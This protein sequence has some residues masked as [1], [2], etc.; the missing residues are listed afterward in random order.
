MTLANFHPSATKP[1]AWCLTPWLRWFGPV[2]N[3]TLMSLQDL[4]CVFG[5]RGMSQIT[6]WSATLA[7]HA[8]ATRENR[9]KGSPLGVA[10]RPS[11]WVGYIIL[12]C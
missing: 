4:D 12:E 7:N 8:V 3:K 9:M 10:S 6:S 5:G 1:L 2:E 11:T